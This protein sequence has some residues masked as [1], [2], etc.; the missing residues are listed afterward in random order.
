LE[1]RYTR[2]GDYRIHSVHAGEGDPVV[3]VHGLSGSHRWWRFTLPELARRHRVHVPELVGFGDSRRPAGRQPTILEMAGVV[4]QW[5]DALRLDR[6][7]LVG[8][9]MGGQILVHVAAATPGRVRRLVLADAAG[10]P[11]MLTV[12]EL[13]RLASEL[14]PP[15]AWGRLTFLPTI[16]L[17]AV[18]AGPLVLHD[19]LRHVLADDIR[20]LLPQIRSPT[21]VVWGELDPLTPLE[22]GRLIAEAIPDAR[23]LVLPGA[24][25]NA[26]ADRPED[27]NRAVLA[28]LDEE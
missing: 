15:R 14:I 17:D 27:F 13:A 22:H 23:L 20:P 6:V 3:L 19:A 24:A 1:R 9:S 8:H 16:A 25:H 28:F 7:D 5:L 2:V 12:A 11:R 10:V 21:L 18:R 4:R 26:M